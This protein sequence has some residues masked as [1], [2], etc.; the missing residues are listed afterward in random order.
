MENNEVMQYVKNNTLTIRVKPNAPRTEMSK[1][2]E[3][4]GWLNIAVHA[5]P[6]DNK[7]NIE[8]IK[9]FTR[10]TK[11]KIEIIRGFTSK[12]KVLKIT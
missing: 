7:A 2:D 9:F 10:M 8:V 4:H 12:V 5:P 1:W 11:K 3:E 6:E